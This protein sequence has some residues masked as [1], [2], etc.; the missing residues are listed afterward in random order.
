M[1]LNLF[2]IIL[3]LIAVYVTW[4]FGE[5]PATSMF[6][7]TASVEVT[8]YDETV[9][10]YGYGEVAQYYPE[11]QLESGETMRLNTAVR[12][13]GDAVRDRWPVNT[14]LDVRLHPNGRVA[15][16][17]NDPRQTLIVPQ[18]I[19]IGALLIIGFSI[20]ASVTGAGAFAFM[21]GMIGTILTTGA[22]VL[23]VLLWS[24]G[25][26]PAT[27]FFWPTENV[28]PATSTV[29][30]EQVKRGLVAWHPRVTVTRD[31]GETVPLRFAYS[32][33]LSEADATSIAAGYE[34]GST[35]SV[36][37]S[38]EGELFARRWHFPFTLALVISFLAPIAGLAGIFLMISALRSKH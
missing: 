34:S 14:E 28:V 17:L 18:M 33:F 1:K 20:W 21:K 5:L 26:P 3:P 8:G 4:S 12:Y 9:S 16:I 35:R 31:T 6:W 7:P 27:S 24:F 19:A 15:Y 11:V 37:V 23:F 2:G 22:T 25:Q 10:D 32:G 30:R 36:R 13:D 38:P 29:E